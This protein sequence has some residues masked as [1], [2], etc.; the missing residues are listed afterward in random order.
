[1]TSPTREI[2]KGKLFSTFRNNASEE[3]LR[4]IV[5]RGRQKLF[6]AREERIRPGRD[7]KILTAWN[8]LMLRSFAEAGQCLDS[9]SYRGIAVRNAKFLLSK[10]RE[11]G[12]L[13]RSYKDGQAKFNAYVEDYAFLVDG[14]ISLYEATFDVQ[15][16]QEAEALAELMVDLF[17]DGQDGGFYFTSAD[18]ESLIHRPKDFTDGAMPSG[19]SA[20]AGALLKLWKL[21]GNAQWSRCAET[22]FEKTAGMVS[23]YPSAFP[24]LLCALDFFFGTTK[25]IAIIGEQRDENTKLLLREVFQAYLPNKVVACGT[26]GRPALLDDRPQ[27][28]GTATAYVCEN[29]TCA[30]PVTAPEA[31]RDQLGTGR[32]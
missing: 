13:L 7:E 24:H 29:F 21:T 6:H 31:L 25:E 32:A 30:M 1:M 3:Q 16:I 8:G 28:D 17:W 22:V 10:L 27:I 23:R 12:R 20:A 14:L 11:N 9:D 18:H 2:S 19:N 5:R 15:W 26:G 4:E